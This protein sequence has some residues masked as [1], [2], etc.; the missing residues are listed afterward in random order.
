MTLGGRD[1]G[2]V[3]ASP[4]TRDPLVLMG[5]KDSPAGMELLV[6]QDK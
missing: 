1:L 3:Q 5:S 6:V 2:V 4:E